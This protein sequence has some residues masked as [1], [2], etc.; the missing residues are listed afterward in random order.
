M[1]SNM[2][3]CSASLLALVVPVALAI[4]VANQN[5]KLQ[6]RQCYVD[7]SGVCPP[8]NMSVQRSTAERKRGVAPR[9]LPTGGDGGVVGVCSLT[10]I[11]RCNL[12]INCSHAVSGNDPL[13]PLQ[14]V[15]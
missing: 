8:Q 9:S 2:F 15:K 13:H 4:P 12:D 3:T 7:R 1:L 6:P 11:A 10:A 14:P 5:Q